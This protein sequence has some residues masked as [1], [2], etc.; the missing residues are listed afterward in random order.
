MEIVDTVKMFNLERNIYTLKFKV[1]YF[2]LATACA[3]SV[4]LVDNSF[5]ES[6]DRNSML[7]AADF[8]PAVR[9]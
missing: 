6:T 3:L 8:A 7:K 5:T 1:D 2:T 9:S 4:E